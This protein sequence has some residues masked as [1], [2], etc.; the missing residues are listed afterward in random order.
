MASPAVTI[1]AFAALVSRPL[2]RYWPSLLHSNLN[3]DQLDVVWGSYPH[4]TKRDHSRPRVSVFPT[5]VSRVTIIIF[6]VILGVLI[7]AVVT[8]YSLRIH[9]SI[10]R[11]RVLRK[12]A[13]TDVEALPERA[14]PRPPPSAMNSIELEP[15]HSRAFSIGSA[16]SSSSSAACSQKSDDSPNPKLDSAS[17][18]SKQ[19]GLDNKSDSDSHGS[20][21][22][23]NQSNR[24]SSASSITSWNNEQDITDARLLHYLSE[25]CRALQP[26]VSHE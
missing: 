18:Q 16:S 17:A 11:Q 20:K 4:V 23:G 5:T 25:C 8:G 9:H 21:Q 10:K 14:G 19:N 7:F 2:G 12:Q 3:T 13:M 15:Y 22:T 6:L 1:R 26:I 24:T